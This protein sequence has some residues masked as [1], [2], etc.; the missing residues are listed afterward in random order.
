MAVIIWQRLSLKATK[1]FSFS[2]SFAAFFWRHRSPQWRPLPSFTARDVI[3]SPFSRSS[4]CFGRVESRWWSQREAKPTIAAPTTSTP[5]SSTSPL[6]RSEWCSRRR[7]PPKALSVSS[8]CWITRLFRGRR[9]F[10]HHNFNYHFCT[11]FERR[12]KNKFWST[13]INGPFFQFLR[14]LALSNCW[15]CLYRCSLLM[16]IAALLSLVLLIRPYIK[17]F[18]LHPLYLDNGRLT[19]FPLRTP[20]NSSF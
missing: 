4:C 15:D 11:F 3:R 2:S 16:V 12:N 9:K 8:C 18:A 14:R 17:V 1:F 6:R 5:P 7:R 13:R 20:P 19:F 10:R